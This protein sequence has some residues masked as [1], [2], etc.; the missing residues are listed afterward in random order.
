MVLDQ[1]ANSKGEE[2]NQRNQ[3]IQEESSRLEKQ[4]KTVATSYHPVPTDNMH[5]SE[6]ISHSETSGS[7]ESLISEID[8]ESKCLF[9]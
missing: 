1:K 7:I 8:N 6:H 2:V 4:L 3:G 5:G 9:T